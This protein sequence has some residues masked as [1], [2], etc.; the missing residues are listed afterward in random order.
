MQRD[1]LVLRC[2]CNSIY[3]LQVSFLSSRRAWCCRKPVQSTN[4]NGLKLW[5]FSDFNK[6]IVVFYPVCQG[7]AKGV[8][9]KIWNGKVDTCLEEST[10]LL[11]FEQPT[12]IGQYTKVP[13]PAKSVHTQH[14]TMHASPRMYRICGPRYTYIV[15]C[16][17][18][19]CYSQTVLSKMTTVAEPRLGVLLFL[20]RICTY[21]L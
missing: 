5:A 16:T 2:L 9:L 10:F 6:H 7:F 11:A 1:R 19:K 15:K 18:L 3:S 21:I 20:N 13:T 4:L 14:A 12:L 8:W 17:I